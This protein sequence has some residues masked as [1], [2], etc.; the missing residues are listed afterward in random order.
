M[1]TRFLLRVVGH[2]DADAVV[3]DIVRRPLGEIAAFLPP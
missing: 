3:P 2:P 1:G